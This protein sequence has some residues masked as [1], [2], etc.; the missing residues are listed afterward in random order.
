MI[1]FNKEIPKYGDLMTIREF[2]EAIDDGCFIDDDGIGYASNGIAEAKDVEI[3]PSNIETYLK[4]KEITHVVW[5][6]K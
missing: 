4:N 1:N 6:N 5:Y 3:Y 2:A